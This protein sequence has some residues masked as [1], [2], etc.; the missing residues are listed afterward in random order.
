[1]NRRNFLKT[2]AGCAA[3]LGFGPALSGCRKDYYSAADFVEV[4]KVDVHVHYN[5]LDDS[6]LTYANSLGMHIV[7]VNTDAGESFNVDEQFEIAVTLRKQHP[8]MMDFLGTFS[9]DDFGKDGF[10]DQIIARI[11]RCMNAGAKGI[12]I[13]KNIGM[14]LKDAQGNYVMADNP[15]FA[16]VFS[17]IEKQHIPMLAHLGEPKNCWLP[18]DQMTI[19]SDLNYYREHP[20][21]HMFRFSEKPSYEDQIVARDHLLERYPKIAFVG[22]HIG[23]L[24]WSIDEVAKRFEAYPNFSVDL[25][26][27]VWYL[28]LQ[29]I[30]DREKVHSFLTTYQDRILY[31]SDIIR[32]DINPDKRGELQ[33]DMK[34]I[35]LQQWKYFATD[36]VIPTNYF[37]FESAPKEMKGLRLPKTIVDKIFGGNAKRFFNL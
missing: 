27:R 18:Y 12:K 9:V 3:L 33:K 32:T 8:G 36:D 7:S 28:Q 5:T 20:E 16:P 13:W 6:F 1:M 34:N 4:P 22:A 10:T 24:E 14:D 31:G 23:S 29:S 11:D 26:E 21:Y 19:Q 37:A 25:A 30:Y 15:V 35:W 2:G 17:Y